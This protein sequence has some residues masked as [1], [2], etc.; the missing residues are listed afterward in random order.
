MRQNPIEGDRL[1]SVGRATNRR[2]TLR[3]AADRFNL[4]AANKV[5]TPKAKSAVIKGFPWT[6]SIEPV[7]Q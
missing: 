5:P 1:T 6:P 4:M 7:Q 2:G 3:F